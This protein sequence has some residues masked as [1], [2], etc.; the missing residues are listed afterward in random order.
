MLILAL[1]LEDR[2][3]VLDLGMM[4]R[5]ALSE[6]KLSVDSPVSFG[7]DQYYETVENILVY[8]YVEKSIPNSQY[9][10]QLKSWQKDAKF[11]AEQQAAYEKAM[12]AYQ[13]RLEQYHNDLDAFN[14]WERQTEIEQ[15]EARLKQLKAGELP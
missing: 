15:L 10:R 2:H 7:A 11:Y 5:Q 12:V 6:Q 14:K 4:I 9:E 3:S 8:A 1:G 13:E